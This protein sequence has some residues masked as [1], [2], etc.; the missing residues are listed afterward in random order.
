MPLSSYGAVYQPA[1]LDLLQRVFDRL[2]GECR[3]ALKDR[4]KREQLAAEVI[5]LFDDGVT[6]EADLVRTV[7][8]RH[9]I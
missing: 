4:E 8:Q 7:S 5:H 3:L 2:C 1:D 6:E 9:R